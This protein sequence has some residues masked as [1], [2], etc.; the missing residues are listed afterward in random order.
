MCILLFISFNRTVFLAHI[1]RRMS[2]PVVSDSIDRATG[3]HCM[4]ADV[5]M[6]AD[7]TYIEYP[8]ISIKVSDYA[9]HI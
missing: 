1:Y 6:E 5:K 2:V 9:Y 3:D 8:E 4:P 7:E